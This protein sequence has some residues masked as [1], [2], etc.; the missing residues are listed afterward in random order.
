MPYASGYDVAAAISGNHSSPAPDASHRC[1]LCGRWEHS[2]LDGLCPSCQDN[3]SPEPPPAIESNGSGVEDVQ[4][5]EP[6]EISR[7]SLRLTEH[8]CAVGSVVRDQADVA[9]LAEAL[10]IAL[11]Q[12]AER[13]SRGERVKLHALGHLS[14]IAG[15]DPPYGYFDPSRVLMALAQEAADV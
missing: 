12:V 4:P 6:R 13:L 5:E 8:V 10:D 3:Y 7:S 2:L 9:T 11:E 15:Q 14:L 1:D